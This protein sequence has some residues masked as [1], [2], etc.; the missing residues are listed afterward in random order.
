MFGGFWGLG[1]G[2]IYGY[3]TA[4]SHVLVLC[5]VCGSGSRECA[6]WFARCPLSTNVLTNLY[7]QMRHQHQSMAWCGILLVFPVVIL[8]YFVIFLLSS[9]D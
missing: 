4:S 2:A 3:A 5:L 7:L 8:I 6:P 9:V 1:G